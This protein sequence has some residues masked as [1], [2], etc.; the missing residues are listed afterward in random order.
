MSDLK[1]TT[2]TEDYAEYLADLFAVQPHGE[3]LGVTAFVAGVE[4]FRG[5]G[6][7]DSRCVGRLRRPIGRV[8]GIGFLH[9][10][11]CDP[12]VCSS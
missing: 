9:R 11:A 4:L 6:R 2:Y 5:P 10:R 7:D 12:G 3:V 8:S 1:V